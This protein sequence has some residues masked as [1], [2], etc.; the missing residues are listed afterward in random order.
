MSTGAGNVDMWSQKKMAIKEG[1]K[2]EIEENR[3]EKFK[4]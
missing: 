4:G 2:K 3:T 1:E